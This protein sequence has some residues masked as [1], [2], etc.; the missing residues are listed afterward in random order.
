VAA[1]ESKLR[2]LRV[3]ALGGGTGLPVV[4]R[5]FKELGLIDG[6]EE[7]DRLVGVV[8]VTDDGGSSGRLRDEFGI[9]PP[10]DVRNCLVAL[11]H[12]EPLMSRLFQARYRSEGALDGHT[13]GNLILAALA[14]ESDGSFLAAVTLAGEVLNIHGTV[15]PSSP[16]SACLNARLS[17]GSEVNG[18]SNIARSGRSVEQVWLDPGDL[19][20]APGVI[21]AIGAADVVVAGPGSLFTSVVPNLLVPEIR[22]A[23]AETAAFRVL[24]VN[25]M[26]EQGETNAFGAVEHLMAV[27]RHLGFEGVDAVLLAADRIPDRTLDRYRSEGANPV[28]AG[29]RQIDRLVPL[30]L[31]RDLLEWTPKVRHEPR[32]TA[33]AVL[34][35]YE[36]WIAEGR[37]RPAGSVVARERSG[38]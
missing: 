34:E 2:E 8:T 29:A 20:A 37:P 32:K 10:G 4:L 21:E 17:D 31:R 6:P 22:R 28:G 26:T 38:S 35:A 24:L 12:N 23:L 18:E 16:T 36:R 27:N 19:E 33:G 30:V 9:I 5:G 1:I 15:L 3:V 7:R 13:A 11:S 25:A 14:Q